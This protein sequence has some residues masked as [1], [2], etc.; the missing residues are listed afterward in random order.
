ME[1]EQRLG[2]AATVTGPE[3]N[4]ANSPR[5]SG[6]R[7]DIPVVVFSSIP[8][9]HTDTHTLGS[10]YLAL[11]FICCALLGLLSVLMLFLR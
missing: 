7:L 1:K 5:P 6:S 4:G 8:S 2:I 10:S 11:A 9:M 3:I